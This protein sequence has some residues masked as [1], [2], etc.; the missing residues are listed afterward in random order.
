ML[1]QRLRNK[2]A[3]YGQQLGLGGEPLPPTLEREWKIDVEVVVELY[4]R[5]IIPLTKILEVDYLICRLEGLSQDEIDR[6][7]KQPPKPQP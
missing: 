6:L 1:L 4:E 2:V 7:M 5:W 3:I